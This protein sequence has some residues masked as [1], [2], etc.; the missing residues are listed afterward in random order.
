MG[1]LWIGGLGV[2][3]RYV[4]DLELSGRKFVSSEGGRWYRTGDMGRFWHDGTIEFLGRTDNQVKLR[5]HRIELGEIEAACE[6]LLPV[7]RTVCVASQGRASTS[8]VAFAQ[9]APIT[10]I[11]AINPIAASDGLGDEDSQWSGFDLASSIQPVLADE[12][13]RAA[14]GQDEALQRSYALQTMRRWEAELSELPRRVTGSTCP[15][16]AHVA[17]ASRR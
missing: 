17:G 5:G 2:A 16:A 13:L 4:D 9:F 6:A 15:P 3:A 14:V 12:R 1:E 11:T 10:E 7:E 8:L